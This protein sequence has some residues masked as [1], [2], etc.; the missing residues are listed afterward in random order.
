MKLL[1]ILMF[2][3]LGVLV[4]KGRIWSFRAQ[5]PADYAALSPKISLKQHLNG[6]IASEGLIYG[7]NGRVS[8]SFVARMEGT[9]SGNTGTLTE[10]FTYSNGKQQKR[11]WALTILDD[12]H[13]TA[14]ADD[15]IGEAKGE[16]SGASIRMTYTIVLPQ[17]AGGH[18]L[19]VT[20]WLYLTKSGVIINR[21]QMRKFGITVAELVATMRPDS[22]SAL[23]PYATMDA[24]E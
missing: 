8:N 6:V 4:L 14:T 23:S 9:W 22:S 13:F 19:R 3:L 11:E 17:E 16:V 12:T 18:R 1:M 15:I 10:A 21:S 7:P 5:T 24:A 2:A 20:D